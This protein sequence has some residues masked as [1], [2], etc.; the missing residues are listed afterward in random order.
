MN[1]Y[2]LKGIIHKIN[3]FNFASGKQKIQ[4][5]FDYQHGRTTTFLSCYS[6]EPKNFS[7]L[8]DGDL[9]E[10]ISYRPVN[11][12]YVNKQGIKVYSTKFEVHEVQKLS[13]MSNNLNNAYNP[14]PVVI[15]KEEM[16]EWEREYKEIKAASD[17]PIDVGTMLSQ[18]Q[19]AAE[20][21]D[22]ID[23]SV[24]HEI[25]TSFKLKEAVDE[26]KE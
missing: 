19:Q 12:S 3:I 7:H 11:E 16:Q 10:L 14:N 18:F 1:K 25:Q 20:T 24:E 13:V 5:Q 6:W 17:K 26:N 4:F 23:T 21:K 22:I 9:I 8:K 2:Q 15:S